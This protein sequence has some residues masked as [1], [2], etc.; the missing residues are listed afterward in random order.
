MLFVA[1]GPV[2]GAGKHVV[3]LSPLPPAV[4]MH[5][6]EGT[7]PATF[8]STHPPTDDRIA[9]VAEQVPEVGRVGGRQEGEG[10]GEGCN[11]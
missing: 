6:R 4:Q 1:S 9:R 8:L 5:R 3:A 11:D 7:V 2:M 10:E